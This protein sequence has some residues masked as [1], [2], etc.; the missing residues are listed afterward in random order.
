MRPHVGRCD[1]APRLLQCRH[2]E[3]LERGR[4]GHVVGLGRDVGEDHRD[5]VLAGV[6][7]LEAC[8]IIRRVRVQTVWV[9][10]RGVPVR[11]RAVVVL[12]VIVVD[13]RV[14]VLQCRRR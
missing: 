8:P 3:R 14:D 1:M 5:G 4:G 13:V 11:G 6:A 12:G 10:Q 9:R 7:A 2:N